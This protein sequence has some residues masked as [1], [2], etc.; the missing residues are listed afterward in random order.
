M[1]RVVA[2][3]EPKARESLL[4][5]SMRE[6][7]L[8]GSSSSSSVNVAAQPSETLTEL[9]SLNIT[10]SVSSP[11]TLA[12]PVVVAPAAGDPVPPSPGPLNPLSL[13]SERPQFA[14]DEAKEEDEDFEDFDDVAED[15]LLDEVRFTSVLR[16][17]LWLT[18]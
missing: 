8:T 3:Q 11:A 13:V 1:D 9:A 6:K 4:T 16:W 14:I 15:G 17:G 7:Q 5:A 10:P 12:V 18:R 2:L